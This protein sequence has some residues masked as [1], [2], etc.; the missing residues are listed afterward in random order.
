[1]G[2][3]GIFKWFILCSQFDTGHTFSGLKWK[4][5]HFTLSYDFI[6]INVLSWTS[7]V[8]SDK[9]KG[10]KCK[11][12]I[13]RLK[14]NYRMYLVFHIIKT[15]CN[16]CKCKGHKN[17]EHNNNNSV[18]WFYASLCISLNGFLQLWSPPPPCGTTLSPV[19]YSTILRAVLCHLIYGTP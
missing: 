6:L 5:W 13:V 17:T 16:C 9:M 14:L 10:K 19:W 1:M 8:S 2:C 3:Y 7:A 4:T 12:S 11:N 18:V 15:N